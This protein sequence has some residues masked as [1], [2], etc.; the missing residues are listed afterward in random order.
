M[1]TLDQRLLEIERQGF[2]KVD[3]Q[4]FQSDLQKM[5]NNANA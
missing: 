2:E 5:I 3:A 4:E 1:S